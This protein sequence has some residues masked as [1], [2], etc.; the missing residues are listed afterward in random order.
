VSKLNV[1]VDLSLVHFVDMGALRTLERLHQQCRSEGRELRLINLRDPIRL[2]VDITGFRTRLPL[3]QPL[4]QPLEITEADAQFEA[5]IQELLL[6]DPQH[7]LKS[8]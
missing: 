7:I 1:C 8:V 5:L 6:T 4:E 3:E 2:T